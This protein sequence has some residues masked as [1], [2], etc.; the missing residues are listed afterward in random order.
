V[1]IKRKKGNIKGVIFQR[2]RT[3]RKDERKVGRTRAN[4]TKGE[5][6]KWGWK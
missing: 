4:Y 3:K 1:G 5:K 6:S 2:K